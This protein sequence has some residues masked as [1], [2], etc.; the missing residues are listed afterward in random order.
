MTAAEKIK[1]CRFYAFAQDLVDP[2]TFHLIEGYENERAYEEH[3]NSDTFL[4]ALAHVVK[5]VR[6]LDRQGVRYDV[7]KLHVDDPRDRVS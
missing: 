6:I 3:E 4:N 1:G 2:N 7:N 5:N